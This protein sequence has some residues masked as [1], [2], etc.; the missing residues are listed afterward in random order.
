MFPDFLFRTH[1]EFQF[2]AA[3]EADDVGEKFQLRVG[4]IAVGA[5]DLPVNVAGVDEEDFVGAVRVGLSLVEKP[6]SAGKRDGVEKIGTDGDHHVDVAGADD[7]F[8]DLLF[9]GAGVGGGVSHDKSGAARRVQGRI[10]VLNPKI[11][12]VV[13]ARNA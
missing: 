11:V 5:A 7:F 8:P 13:G 1:P 12:S 9:G 2:L 6:K 3:I 4:E 10:K